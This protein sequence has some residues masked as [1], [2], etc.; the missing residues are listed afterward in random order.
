MDNE[1]IKSLETRIAELEKFI[2]LIS[3]DNKRNITFSN[4]QIGPVAL[5]K[6]KNITVENNQIETGVF[7]A[8]TNHISNTTIHNFESA[9]SKATVKDCEIHNYNEKR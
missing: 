8:L 9:H 4:C 3:I 2:G 5:E 6:C 7:A 1:Y